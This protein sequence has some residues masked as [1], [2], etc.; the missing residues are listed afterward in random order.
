MN[1]YCDVVFVSRTFCALDE[2]YFLFAREALPSA[3]KELVT[4]VTG[5]RSA[6]RRRREWNERQTN[7][8][9][10]DAIS[11]RPVEIPVSLGAQRLDRFKRS[12]SGGTSGGGIGWILL[13]RNVQWSTDKR[14][15][16]AIG[17]TCNLPSVI[18]WIVQRK[19]MILLVFMFNKYI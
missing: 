18:A 19:A 8:V 7:C 14:G 10:N 3:D 13:K 16:E 6:G 9:L 17:L 5:E 1:F 4:P 11:R 12:W 15:W 2:I